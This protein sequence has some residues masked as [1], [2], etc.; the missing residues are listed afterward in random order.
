MKDI[1]PVKQPSF[2]FRIN[3]ALSKWPHFN[4]AYL[5]TVCKQMSIAVFVMVLYTLGTTFDILILEI[6]KSQNLLDLP[7]FCWSEHIGCHSLFLS[8]LI[9]NAGFQNPSCL[10]SYWKYLVPCFEVLWS[11]TQKL[12]GVPRKLDIL[13]VGVKFK[14]SNK[15]YVLSNL[16]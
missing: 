7:R 13:N 1:P 2:V 6:Q 4:R 3:Y 14:F 10:N 12:S 8:N 5:V 9:F 15:N 16:F 11:K